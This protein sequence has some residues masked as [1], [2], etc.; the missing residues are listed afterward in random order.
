LL[1][2]PPIT[3]RRE[4]PSPIDRSGLGGVD[5]VSGRERTVGEGV[6]RV[7]GLTSKPRDRLGGLADRPES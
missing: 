4:E 3:Q 7:G 6:L 5:L 1:R 2:E